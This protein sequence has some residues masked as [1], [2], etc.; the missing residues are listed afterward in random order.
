MRLSEL[1][2]IVIQVEVLFVHNQ[3]GKIKYVNEQGN[4]KAPRFF[5]G[6]TR[7][8]SITRYH[9]DLDD[10][11]VGKIEKL[12]REPSNHIEIAK[13][14]HVLN[15]ERTVKNIWMG[16]AFM[17]SNNLHKPTRT[18]QITEKNKELLRENFPNL[19]EQ[20]EWR[21]PYFA[22]VK[23]EKV[24]S[25]CCSARSTPVAAEASVET[26]VEF[27][28]NGY[29]T[30]V[31]TAWAI[32]IQEENRV[33]LYST[34]WDNYASQEVARKLKLINYGMNLHIT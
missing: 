22:I 26:L 11:T 9:C 3:V 24:V 32:S 6:R 1:D 10:E 27:Q 4:T 14:I 2:L 21:Q 12:I 18:I 5:L 16:P 28:G 8:G 29:G 33:P 25:I 30:D 31:V 7:E 34:S 20:M 17:F 23:N 19:I 15:E 13:I